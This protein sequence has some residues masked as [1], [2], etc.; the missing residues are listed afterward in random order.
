MIITILSFISI[1][2]IQGYE[3]KGDERKGD[4]RLG[5]ATCRHQADARQVVSYKQ[6]HPVI[7]RLSA[8][9]TDVMKQIHANDNMSTSSQCY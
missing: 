5:P 9:R 7:P 4:E 6:C 3:R 2:I 1:I 8:L